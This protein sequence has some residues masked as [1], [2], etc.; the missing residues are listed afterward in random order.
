MQH[1][2]LACYKTIQANTNYMQTQKTRRR[3][4]AHRH[5]RRRPF[6]VSHIYIYRAYIRSLV[7]ALAF[8]TNTHNTVCKPLTAS[9]HKY[10]ERASRSLECMYFAQPAASDTRGGGGISGILVE[11]YRPL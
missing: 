2:V 1:I 7:R 11:L 10:R 4:Q 5:C 8:A 6:C 9:L 3:D